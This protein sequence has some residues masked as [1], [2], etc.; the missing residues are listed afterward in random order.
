MAKT[1]YISITDEGKAAQFERFRDTIG[2]Y[3]ITLGVTASEL[4]DQADDATW[5]RYILNHSL[6]MRDS[7]SQWTSYKNLLLAGPGDG[8]MPA[9][10]LTPAPPAPTPNNMPPGILIRFRDLARRIKAAAPYTEA[11]GEALGIIGSAS[12]APDPSTLAPQ[13]SLR[14][15][16]GK[17][18]VVWNK[19]AM[20]GIEIQVDRGTGVWQFLAIDTRPDYT[21]TTPFPSPPA[22]WK[23]RANYC[24]GSERIGQW[25]NVAEITVGG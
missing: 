20:P 1:D 23:Y 7:G 17:V 16:S 25:S 13:I 15:A 19:N 9:T 18:E 24:E 14:A 2:T 6:V 5:F 11:I 10:P 22:K 8:S 21:D 3:S 4:A 12:T